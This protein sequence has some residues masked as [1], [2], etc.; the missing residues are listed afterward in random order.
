MGLRLNAGSY[1][2]SRVFSVIKSVLLSPLPYAEPERLTLLWTK[3]EKVGLKQNWVS[4]PEVLDFREQAKFF[5]GF[6]VI[7]G[8][9]RNFTLTG[10]GDPEQLH[11][12]LVSTNLF[13]L[14]GVKVKI[15]RDFDPDE[16]KPG[17]PQVAI[18]SHGFWQRRFAGDQAV[19][20]RTINLS[21]IPTT[22]VGVLPEHFAL[23]LPA[24]A[25]VP[26]NL[27][28]WTPYAVDYAKQHRHSHGMT[29]IGRLKL[30]VTLAQAQAE[31]DAIAA[32]IYPLYYTDSGFAVKVVSMHGDIVKQ[33]RPMLL[34]LLG[35]VGF[36]LLIACAN[37]ANLLLARATTREKEIAIRAALGAGRRR[38][39]QQ[40][41]SE[42]VLLSLPG[43]LCGVLLAVLGVYALPR[44]SPG[45][46]P[47]VDEVSIDGWVLLYT[48]ALTVLT[49]MLFGLF[50][51]IQSSK[52]D[53]TN[54]LREGSRS[55]ASGVGNRLRNVVVVGEIALSLVL[56]LGA[57]L[58]MRSFWH[59]LKV[60]PGFEPRN[61]LAMDLSLPRSKYPDG[62]TTE[63]FYRQA[64]EKVQ[65]LPGVE[66]AAAISQLPLVGT[67][68]TGPMTFEGVTAN[69]QRGNLASFEVDQRFI[70]PDYFTVMKTPLLAGRF[71]TPQDGAGQPRVAIIDETLAR[72]L[73]PNSSPLGKRMTLDY[74]F[75][76]KPE[77]W[78]EI[79]GVV[80]HIRYRRLDA[81]VREQVYFAHAQRQTRD[82]TLAIRTTS[83][84][85]NMVSAVR[86]GLRSID[87]DQP[88]SQIR[89]LDQLVANALAPARFTLF[90]LTI[91]GSVAG[92]L[93]IV[94][95]YSVIAYVVTQ[96]TREIGIR[97]ALGA[98]A[99]DM[100]Y[101]FIRQG[102]ILT[103]TGLAIGLVASFALLQS[104][105]GLLYGVSATDPLTFIVTSSALALVALL[106]CWIPA[107]RAA[108]VDPMIALRAE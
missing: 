48:L 72:R 65:A 57:G 64:L 8:F 107:R 28:I 15:G 36:V 90:L 71:F 78:Y 49:G 14:L 89:T 19:I 34:I 62:S 97:M 74:R 81:D 29:V 77:P 31:M 70:T 83:D 76:E 63:N 104:M 95:I 13:S 47:R 67:S 54:S 20:G 2:K 96:R 86:Q 37:V 7:N 24:E 21:G 55:V 16:E 84:P 75:L 52:I 82:M 100:L 80:K 85:L 23:L 45:N 73:W 50:P 11:G 53:L 17:A 93:A 68:S 35:A 40:L 6:G 51:A 99:S 9:N 5:E 91:F 25:Q 108:K 87:P 39:M 22:V 3:A 27:D 12:A 43:G 94:G 26:M 4:E 92:V 58:I 105:K 88:V 66:S 30:G 59:L 101:L 33:T 46:L 61:V 38:V 32:R 44:L 79:V 18:L 102:I 42:S 103:M 41:L 69:A 56:L 1:R 106:A 98:R 10:G 60:D